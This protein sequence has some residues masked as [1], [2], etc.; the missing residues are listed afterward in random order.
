MPRNRKHR[1]D[2]RIKRELRAE[3]RRDSWPQNAVRWL[4]EEKK[5]HQR[6]S[7]RVF[8][9]SRI[10]RGTSEHNWEWFIGSGLCRHMKWLLNDLT[11][12][13]EHMISDLIIMT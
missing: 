1:N 8:E 11:L 5:A 4:A 2:K 12:F 7:G 9:I 13:V 3:L 6:C 10:S